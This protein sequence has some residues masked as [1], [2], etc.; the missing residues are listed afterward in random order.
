MVLTYLFTGKFPSL[1]L[2]GEKPE[3]TL[4]TADEVVV[5]VREQVDKAKAASQPSELA[6]EEGYDE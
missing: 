1:E 5:L 4:M 3:V 2:S 6:E